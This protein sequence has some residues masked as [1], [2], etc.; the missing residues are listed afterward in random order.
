MAPSGEALDKETA[1]QS[2]VIPNSL[3]PRQ[4]DHI[5]THIQYAYV[6]LQIQLITRFTSETEKM[7]KKKLS[8][9]L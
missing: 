9:K 8:N 1:G 5:A 6:S 4:C 7:I 2:S 3:I